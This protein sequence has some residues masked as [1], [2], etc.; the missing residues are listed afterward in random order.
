MLGL[1][2]AIMRYISD[3]PQPGI[4]ECHLEDAHG[5]RWSFVE[6]TAIVS[7]QN[8]DAQA[9]YPQ[10]GVVA[11]QMIKRSLDGTGREVIRVDTE[12]PWHIE[13]IEGETQ[14]D[15]LPESLVEFN[16]R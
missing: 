6:K 15:V 16:W 3:E 4:V 8:L 1:K 12:R 13:S 7:T 5:R 2:V 14:F 9:A 10:D 11:C